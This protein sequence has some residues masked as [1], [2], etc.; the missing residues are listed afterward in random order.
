MVSREYVPLGLILFTEVIGFTLILP[1]LPYFA[2]E[3][4]ASPFIVGLILASFPFC[5]FFSAPIIGRLSDRFGRKTMLIVSQ[6]STLAGFL[7]LGFANSLWM[8]FL[9]RIIDGLFGS[10]MTLTRTYISDITR[11]KERAKGYSYFGA[12]EGLG[13]FIGP[14]IG[15]IFSL[16]SYS[17]PSF[18]AAGMTII[19]IVLT[20]TIL[21]ETVV[22][23]ER[24]SVKASDFF[25]A[26]HF[27]EGLKI[28]KLR[29]KFGEYFFFFLGFTMVLS[30]LALFVKHQLGFGPE[31]VGIIL[32]LFG[33][34]RVIYQSTTIPKLIDKV[35]EVKLKRI[36]FG[37]TILS[38]V[39][40]LAINSRIAFYT[41][42]PIWGIGVG[43]T[44]PMI[45]SEVS[46]VP[47]KEERGKIMGV[48]DSL[49]SIAQ[50]IGPLV[51][52]FLIT[53]L[54]PPSWLGPIAAIIV[55]IGLMI[56]FVKSKDFKGK[57][58]RLKK[59]AKNI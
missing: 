45:I 50:I 31:E 1:F 46:R 20:I 47:K 24:V 2:E 14:A 22:S 39:F 52:G 55:S 4:G 37:V 19:S 36:G 5:Q 30:V 21:E 59:K 16:I 27:F 12:V 53:I 35:D 9:S 54:D 7:I 33:L 25:P 6:L 38:L 56:T 48:L 13:W 10:N 11:G 49:N 26:K 42:M 32:M 43:M 58:R 44:R 17:L 3:F 57:P 23:K 34:L 41:I 18:F 8:I 28:K 51:G 29:K 40:F 15:G